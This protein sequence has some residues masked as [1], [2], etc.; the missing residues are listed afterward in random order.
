MATLGR[1]DIEQD[2]SD[3]LP[4]NNSKQIKAQQHRS[5]LK[6]FRE[7]FFNL[8]D[9][10]LDQLTYTYQE[11][12]P[13]TLD[14]F[15]QNYFGQVIKKGMTSSFDIGSVNVG[16]DLQVDG[17]I[18]AA[19][20]IDNNNHITLIKIDFNENVN[21]KVK[22][23]VLHF[24]GQWDESNHVGYPAIKDKGGYIEMGISEFRS[25]NQE[26]KIEII[27]L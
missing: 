7:S 19:K 14:E 4:T 12:E 11:G 21:G 17:V 9:D 18:D 10:Q 2:V 23:P 25:R 1:D 3:K 27:I 15:I 16:D 20:V 5:V 26:I 22:I 13:V 24:E 6:N 8:I